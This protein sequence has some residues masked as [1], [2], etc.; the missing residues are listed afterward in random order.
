MNAPHLRTYLSGLVEVQRGKLVSHKFVHNEAV[1]TK[2][3][4]D[5]IDIRQV[6]G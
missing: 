1:K 2:S 4:R 3:V 6:L 5:S